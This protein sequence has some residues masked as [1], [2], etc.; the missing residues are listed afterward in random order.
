MRGAGQDKYKYT[1]NESHP[2]IGF[3]LLIMKNFLQNPN[4]AFKERLILAL[5]SVLMLTILVENNTGLML[6]YY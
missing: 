5:A 4:R 1:R 2:G 3:L 6:G